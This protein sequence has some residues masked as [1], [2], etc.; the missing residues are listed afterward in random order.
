MI[1]LYGYWRSSAS[2]RVRW[3]LQLKKIEYEYTAINLLKAEQ[4]SPEHLKRSPSGVVP[5][6]EIENGKFINQSIPTILYLEEKYPDTYK[7]FGSSLV[8]KTEILSLC[9]IINADTAPLQTPRVQKRHT[10]DA[11]EQEKWCQDFIRQGFQSFDTAIKEA[12]GKFSFGDKV[13][14]A[15][16]FL[17]PQIYNAI[18]YKLDVQKEFPKLFEIYRQCLATPEGLASSPEKQSDAVLT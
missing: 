16:L 15:D 7:L 11:V 1:K 12:K 4:K 13:T 9:E 2:W 8:E 3:A 14:A 5:V 17:V 18:R 6:L 10:S